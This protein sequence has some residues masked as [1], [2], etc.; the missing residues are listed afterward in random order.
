[1]NQA[2]PANYWAYLNTP[3]E[4]AFG[5][6]VLESAVAYG[7]PY[8]DYL[9]GDRS[10]PRLAGNLGGPWGGMSVSVRRSDVY[11][12]EATAGTRFRGAPSVSTVTGDDH[13]ALLS[14]LP[15]LDASS[16]SADDE[17]EK[18]FVSLERISDLG[19]PSS[20][21]SSA[22][23]R[24]RVPSDASWADPDRSSPPISFDA[25]A[26]SVVQMVGGDAQMAAATAQMAGPANLR[27]SYAEVTSLPPRQRPGY[28]ENKRKQAKP[29][30]TVKTG[31]PKNIR[32][33]DI[34]RRLVAETAAAEAAAAERRGEIAARKQG[35]IST[36]QAAAGS[37]HDRRRIRRDS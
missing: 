27:P 1:M 13:A 16:S 15:L 34:E 36:L 3:S 8:Y 33:E 6:A 19:K 25:A 4:D 29:V 12:P 28:S 32:A 26:M 11:A 30:R 20:L 14:G 31:D 2:F 21:G 10:D 18:R 37:V 5:E 23:S 35:K 7:E 17:V 9:Y 22:S 24:S